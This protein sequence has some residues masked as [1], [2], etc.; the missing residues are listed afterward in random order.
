M[1]LLA[2]IKKDNLVARKERDAIRSTLLTTL[3]GEAEMVGKNAG[4]RESTDDE[5]SAVI[6]KFIKNNDETT[7]I[8]AKETT[9]S[10]ANTVAT[11][12]IEK[13]LLV[14]YLP[15]QLTEAELE[16]E[17]AEISASL[18]SPNVGAVMKELRAR[19]GNNYDG[20]TASSLAAKYIAV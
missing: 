16:R 15:K 9:V 7:G 4:N 10:A 14:G 2:Q 17:V 1:S 5:V 12:A 20:K 3:I 19:H 11:L 18:T 6:R 13:A 8:L